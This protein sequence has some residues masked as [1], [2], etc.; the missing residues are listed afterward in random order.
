MKKITTLFLLLATL[1]GC[2]NNSKNISVEHVGGQTYLV[3]Q[4]ENKAFLVNN[5][6]L[7]EL[8]KTTLVLKDGEKLSQTK[9]ISDGRLNVEAKVK[10]I[11]SQALYILTVS[12]VLKKVKEGELEVDDKSNFEWFETLKSDYSSNKYISIQFYDADG[13]K[14]Q[15]QEVKIAARA[16]RFVDGNGGYSS[17]MYEGS[18]SITPNKAK[19]IQNINFIWNI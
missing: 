8:E 13:F 5:N 15:E 17:Y 2:D 16:T 12:P 18:I 19:H 4:K 14:L 3:N 1:S 7:L 10:F 6:K 11:D 9:T